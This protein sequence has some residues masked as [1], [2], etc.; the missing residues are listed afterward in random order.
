MTKVVKIYLTSKVTD[1]DGNSVDYKDVK[2]ILWE[3]QKQTREIK[4]KA[5]QL[6]WQWY[7][8]F[9]P[10]F[11]FMFG[12]YPTEKNTLG[13]TLS[14]WVY[15][16]L[17]N[18]N[19]LNSGNYTAT[20]KDC[21]EKFKN[22]KVE[23]FKGDKSI[24][25][26]KKD[27]PLDL[28]NKSI[29]LDYENNKFSVALSLLNKAAM[30]KYNINRFAFECIVKDKSTRTILERCYDGI[31]K[32]S[33]SKFVYDKKKRMWRLNLCY[34]FENNIDNSLN[35]NK[36]LGIDLGVS[37][38][39]VA[40]IYGD[41]NRFMIDGNEIENFRNKTEA[42]KIS[43][44]K[45]CKYCAD[46][47]IGHGYYTRTASVNKLGGKVSQFRETTNYK[48]A[49]AVVKYAVKNNCGTI[50]MEDLTGIS[51]HGESFLKKWSYY[52]LQAKIIN[53]AAEH[54]IKTI[55]VD[56]YCTSRRC[57]KCGYIDEA[58]RQTQSEFK[59]LNCG[60]TANADYNAS[61]NIAIRDIDKIIKEWCSANNYGAN[62]KQTRIA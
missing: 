53:K 56:P 38:P 4:N 37:K 2:N 30:K 14:G 3:L 52:D 24:V 26:Y 45:Q 15:D 6:C 59:C 42:R 32:I 35:R 43:L 28:H 62:V 20:T 21:C 41:Y 54:G 48:Y 5:I 16:K 11:N 10:E 50:Q 23:Y 9:S 8:G 51:N 55:K 27:Q 12:E 22:D 34:S 33:A 46:G 58:N 60:F 1:K 61:Q 44:L 39:V 29:T 7:Y 17:K 36:I 49:K 19:D 31:Y 40:S 57:S 13:Y 47:R 25:N 18:D